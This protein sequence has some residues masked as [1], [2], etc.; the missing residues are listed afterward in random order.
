M[1]RNLK[2]LGLALVAALA[3]SAVATAG[4]SAQ[5]HVFRTSAG[6][7]AHLTAAA[8]N[9]QVFKASTNDA[10][11]FWARP[12]LTETSKPGFLLAGR[13]P[14]KPWQGRGN[15]LKSCWSAAPGWS[16]SPAVPS[17]T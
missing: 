17:P 11:E 10:K 6:Q 2:T 9:D 8:T 5:A 13:E 12:G 14:I 3:L 16:S 1:T 7:T 4:A 15:T